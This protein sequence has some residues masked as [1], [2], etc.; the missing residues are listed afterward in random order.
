MTIGELFLELISCFSG[1]Y[2][3]QVTAQDAD[4][5][6]F[7]YSAKLAYSISHGHPYFS[8][9]PNTG[10]SMLNCYIIDRNGEI[11]REN[12]YP[13]ALKWGKGCT[14]ALSFKQFSRANSP[15][16]FNHC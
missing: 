10:Q 11:E 5:E 7:G 13:Y 4:D 6:M 1:T 3:T 8:V 16:E 2:V 9:E 15:S 14:A 12:V